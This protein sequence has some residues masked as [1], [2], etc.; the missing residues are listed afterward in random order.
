M[1]APA[2]IAEPIPAAIAAAEQTESGT[3][4]FPPAF[5][6]S[7]RPNTAFDM[8]QRVPGFSFDPGDRVR[9]FGGAAGNVLVGGRRPS[10]KADSLSEILQ[11]IPAA[12]VARIELIRG[13]AP[14][15]D[16][17]G[18]SVVVNVVLIAG[19]RTEATAVG[20]LRAYGDGRIAP[21]GEL[22]WSRSGGDH[23]LSA[24]AGYCSAIARPSATPSHALVTSLF[25]ENRPVPDRPDPGS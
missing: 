17:Q 20:A 11:R 10:S 1:F 19:A 23:M 14:G 24:S 16:M 18:R 7:A 12:S 8:V 21:N 25:W 5:F 15:I 3:S 6:A 9:G 22:D 13:A 4:V 2:L